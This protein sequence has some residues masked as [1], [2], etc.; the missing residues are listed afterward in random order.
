MSSRRE[1]AASTTDCGRSLPG[2]A[3]LKH[4]AA[5]PA[6]L[7]AH[8]SLECIEQRRKSLFGHPVVR[9]NAEGA[10]VLD[11][12]WGRDVVVAVREIEARLCIHVL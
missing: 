7:A 11:E 8:C 1:E 4:G 9:H 5:L 2:A 6:V 3:T 12:C 10:K